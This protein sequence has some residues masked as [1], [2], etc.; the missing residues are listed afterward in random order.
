[1]PY[2]SSRGFVISLNYRSDC[3]WEWCVPLIFAIKICQS[4]NIIIIISLPFRIRKKLAIECYVLFYSIM[5]AVYASHL[6][7]V[8]R[9]HLLISGRRSVCSAR[10]C[11]PPVCLLNITSHNYC[12][13]THG[14]VFPASSLIFPPSTKDRSSTLL[15]L[16]SVYDLQVRRIRRN[17]PLIFSNK[18]VCN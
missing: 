10:R 6:T 14:L 7:W 13:F 9:H 3:W 11:S 16:S 15:P 12:Y 17:L 4:D 5:P 8:V 18:N 2:Q 1:M